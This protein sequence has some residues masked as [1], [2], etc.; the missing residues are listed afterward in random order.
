MES[1]L[2][3]MHSAGSMCAYVHVG[4]TSDHTLDMEGVRPAMSLQKV[5]SR[6]ITILARLGTSVF[7]PRQGRSLVL[8]LVIRWRLL[9]RR[10]YRSTS[11]TVWK[12]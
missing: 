6:I 12:G 5:G 4:S 10:G 3:S 8:Q 9:V 1:T 7:L 11:T 2:K